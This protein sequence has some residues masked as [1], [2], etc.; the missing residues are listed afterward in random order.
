MSSKSPSLTPAI[1]S[2]HS[3]LVYVITEPSGW[4]LPNTTESPWRDT[5]T[6]APPSHVRETRQLRSPGADG[7]VD[8]LSLR[9]FVIVNHASRS[10]CTGVG[11]SYLVD[12]AQRVTGGKGGIT[13]VFDGLAVPAQVGRLL[14]VLIAG[15]ALDEDHWRKDGAFLEL[16]ENE[17]AVLG[18]MCPS[19][20]GHHLNGHLPALLR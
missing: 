1:N 10:F 8:I 13:Q 19:F 14:E 12:A 16:K 4:P 6:H 20:E 11:F 3:A 9:F 2:F 15:K 17:V 5:A 7:F 18:D